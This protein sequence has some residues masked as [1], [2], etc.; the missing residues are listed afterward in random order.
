MAGKR[1]G[2]KKPSTK[3]A[4]RRNAA[5]ALR[6]RVESVLASGSM[7]EVTALSDELP[8]SQKEKMIAI[9]KARARY[10]VYQAILGGHF[11][12]VKWLHSLGGKYPL[13]QHCSRSLVLDAREAGHNDIATWLRQH[14]HNYN[15]FPSRCRVDKKVWCMHAGLLR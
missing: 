7:A 8:K 9:A 13:H 2:V 11:A 14:G 3:L 15:V 5:I 10:Y 12:I 1:E 4:K 6:E